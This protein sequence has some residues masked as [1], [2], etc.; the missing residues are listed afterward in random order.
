MVI[1]KI[2]TSSVPSDS[3]SGKVHLR[4]RS[5]DL[6]LTHSC[7]QH[8]NRH[9]RPPSAKTTPVTMA[10]HATSLD[11]AVDDAMLFQPAG[12]CL[13][14]L[15]SGNRTCTAKDRNLPRILCMKCHQLSFDSRLV[16]SYSLS[17]EELADYAP[18]S[19][20]K[21]VRTPQTAEGLVWP[22]SVCGSFITLYRTGKVRSFGQHS[23]HSDQ[24]RSPVE[25]NAF[26]PGSSARASRRKKLKRKMSKVHKSLL[27]TLGVT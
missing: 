23:D 26:K 14:N 20:S 4:H 25:H 17:V 12:N 13:V 15:A 24:Q 7:L 1:D 5:L 18:L 21:A 16:I 27:N 10:P 22:C 11:V 3:T 8:N 19:T 9:Y 6:D 2:E